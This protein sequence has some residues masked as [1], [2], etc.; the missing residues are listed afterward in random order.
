MNP[1][2]LRVRTTAVVLV[3]FSLVHLLT[4]RRKGGIPY[5]PP[6]S[7]DEPYRTLT[8]FYDRRGR[9]AGGAPL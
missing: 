3:G 9:A 4:L 5:E 7:G 8:N 2:D 6:P 1:K